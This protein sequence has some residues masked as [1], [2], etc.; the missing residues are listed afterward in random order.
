MNVESI[1]FLALL[2][3]QAGICKI[4]YY[5]PADGEPPHAFSMDKLEAPFW[6]NWG[7]GSRTKGILFVSLL[8]I[9]DNS[10]LLRNMD[11]QKAAEWVKDELENLSEEERIAHRDDWW[12]K[13][14]SIETLRL[15]QKE[16]K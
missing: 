4:H 3:G 9:K 6:I 16:K 5:E 2:A 10:H 1:E 11:N 7:N 8:S 12:A 14:V 13:D 15:W